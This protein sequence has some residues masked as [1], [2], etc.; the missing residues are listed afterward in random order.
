[1]REEHWDVATKTLTGVSTV[2]GNDL[3]ELRIVGQSPDAT[4]TVSDVAVLAEDRAAGV[5]IK[6]V[7]ASDGVVKVQITS[8]AS[9]EVRWTVRF[10]LVR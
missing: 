4:W 1:M 8:A 10:G 3:Y 2:V 7:G 6:N 9:R 5:T